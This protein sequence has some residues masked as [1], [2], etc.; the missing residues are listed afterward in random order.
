MRFKKKKNKW[1]MIATTAAM[2]DMA[3]L[4]IVFFMASTSIDSQKKLNVNL[5]N[6]VSEE[7]NKDNLAISITKE[8]KLF[9][10]GKYL[11]L[12]ELEGSL[13]L[14]N[15]EK[16]KTVLI[17]ADKSLAYNYMAEV[18]TVLK[19]AE[20]LNLVFLSKNVKNEK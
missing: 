1:A 11:S 16:N 8:N 10:N 3:F 20:F 18:L 19:R 2:A 13:K 6:V 12:N 5:P 9:F 14:R 7:A 4:L 17:N 15:K